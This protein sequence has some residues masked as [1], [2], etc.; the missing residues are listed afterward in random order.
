MYS[1]K[2][3]RADFAMPIALQMQP[4]GNLDMGADDGRR[5]DP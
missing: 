2:W 4:T 1:H 3:L 5:M